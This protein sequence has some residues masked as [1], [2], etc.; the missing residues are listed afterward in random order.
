ML[1]FKKII[2]EGFRSFS[3]KTTV[4]LDYPG[5]VYLGG[6]NGAG[7]STIFDALFW[8]L[9]GKSSRGL[10]AGA[11]ASWSGG[12]TRVV[13]YFELSGQQCKLVR[14]WKPNSLTLDGAP[15]SQEALEEQLEYT[16]DTFLFSIY[17][18]QFTHHFCDLGAA[19]QLEVFTELLKLDLW[20][21][22][23]DKASS[24][25][26]EYEER[27]QEL[28]GALDKASAVLVELRRELE[29]KS[30]Q[31]AAW[32]RQR[33]SK[34]SEL[35]AEL[36][37]VDRALKE[38]AEVELSP[39]VKHEGSSAKL[40]QTRD[41][42][43]EHKLALTRIEEQLRHES[44]QL[45]LLHDAKRCPLC[46]QALSKETV[47][48]R[49][50]NLAQ[51]Q[52]Q[53]KEAKWLVQSATDLERELQAK[54]LK[55]DERYKEALSAYED[56]R[57]DLRT[58]KAT[59][60]AKKVGIKKQLDEVQGEDCPFSTR[61]LVDRIAK[62]EASWD[63]ANAGMRTTGD[64]I[65]RAQY[66]V[67]A[68]KNIR[69]MLIDKHLLQFELQANEALVQLGLEGWYIRFDIEKE[70]KSGTVRRGFTVEIKSPSNDELVPFEVWSGG[71]TQRLRF[72]IS[73]AF[74]DLIQDV[75]G[76]RCNLEVFDEPTNF[77]TDKGIDDMLDS[78]HARAEKTSVWL[79]DHRT[80]EH[81]GFDHSFTVLKDRQGSSILQ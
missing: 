66:W 49:K 56:K 20:D 75:S 47:L 73:F 8:C 28:K 79:I 72:A 61:E 9:F 51:L 12:R 35:K 70:N 58:S 80:L 46:R 37:K 21:R 5:L 10:R 40:Q 57:D 76:Q 71:E 50:N 33:K 53:E 64:L 7:K 60:E 78:L 2:I 3:V 55:E 11:V 48:G 15:I 69:L 13:V 65:G 62:L 34:L 30:A 81:G 68:F 23:S 22:A 45:D 24:S 14:T 29:E 1:A 36:V 6:D 25:E 26:K 41:S 32:L 16:E 39:P 77:L 38:L 44:D 63:E 31:E 67:K 42:M 18:A 59:E 43:A 17:H 52:A 19:R 27:F 74:A 4:R 54:V